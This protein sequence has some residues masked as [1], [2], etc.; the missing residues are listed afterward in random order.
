LL[1]LQVTVRG[2]HKKKTKVLL[3]NLTGQVDGGAQPQDEA[4]DTTTN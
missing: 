1:L 4:G 2:K 3:D